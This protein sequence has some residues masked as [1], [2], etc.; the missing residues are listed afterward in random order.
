[1]TEIC[2]EGIEDD[3]RDQIEI[4]IK[5]ALRI[6]FENRK[7]PVK[8][9][10]VAKD[11]NETV[12]RFLDASSWEKRD[13]NQVHEYGVA[14]AKTIPEFQNGEIYFNLILDRR[15]F[16]NSSSIG[17][18]DRISIFIHEFTHVLDYKL[19]FD[20]VGEKD[21]CSVPKSKKETLFS[22]ALVIWHEYHAERNVFE[23]YEAIRSEKMQFEYTPKLGHL[24]SLKEFLTGL[25]NFLQ[26]SILKFR[27]WQLTPGK[28]CWLITRR[29]C[30]IL[31]LYAYVFALSDSVTK[32]R[33]KVAELNHLDGY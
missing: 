12:K 26:E 20:S 13:Y 1:M 29:V 11:F 32:L 33:D 21:F 27:N 31:F 19:R 30:D 18:L 25:P 5:D 7:N 23:S 4:E 14:F 9:M 10:V 8:T 2:L 15:L 24:E 28:I 17:R 22:N 3:E 6:F 16:Q